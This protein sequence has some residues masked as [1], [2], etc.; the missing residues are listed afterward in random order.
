MM[1]AALVKEIEERVEG[2][3]VR[4][5]RALRSLRR[6]YSRRIEDLPP[7]DVVRIA[8]ALIARRRVPRFI[9]DELI[10]SRPDALT[11]L[12]QAQLERL[13][14]GI[15]SWDQVDCFACYLAG[16]AWRENRIADKAIV[17]WATSKDRWW[18]RAALVSTVPLNVKARGGRGDARRTL[19]ICALLV[20]DRDEIVAKA[21]S[22]ALRAL[23]VRDAD[24]ARRFVAENE[25]RLPA[26][27]RREV[28]Q[29][30]ATGRKNPRPQRKQGTNGSS[31]T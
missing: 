11:S 1:V 28:R 22:W 31:S 15:S 6:E 9:G 8:E 25:A 21:L 4:T 2:T 7:E 14:S 24:A 30:L 12:D 19:R 16:P 29:K 23:A 26:L 17:Q 13:G 5:A 20:D 10:A 18:R 3:V 27:V